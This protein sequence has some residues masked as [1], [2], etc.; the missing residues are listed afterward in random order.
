[1]LFQGT[2]ETGVLRRNRLLPTSVPVAVGIAVLLLLGLFGTVNAQTPQIPMI[3]SGEV[4]VGGELVPDGLQ[5][6]ARIGEYESKPK[7]VKNGKY[8][9][10][11]VGPP[12]VV[13]GGLVTFYLEGVEATQTK[14]WSIGYINLKFNL[15]FPSLP[16]PTPT[17]TPTPTVTPTRTAT[18]VPPTPTST[19][20]ASF[21]AVYSGP[22]V[23]AGGVVPQ[24]AEL[25]AKIDDYVSTPGLIKGEEYRNLVLAPGDARLVG[26][27][28]EFFLGEF[29]AETTDIYESGAFKTEFSLIFL[30]L[31]QPTATVTPMPPTETSVPEPTQTKTPVPSPISTSSPVPPK[32]TP[33]Q[34]PVPP[35]ETS[36]PEPTQTRTPVPSPTPTSS[37][38]PPT[39]TP[40]Q[41]PIPATETA[42][43]APIPTETPMPSGGG[44]LTGTSVSPGTA[45]V[46]GMLMFAPI[47]LLV[48]YRRLRR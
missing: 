31:P 28:I 26:G 39:S 3:F 30:G 17:I 29:R 27:T 34:T 47:A 6:T 13:T 24:G 44:C 20:E 14:T 2:V 43:S 32:S 16:V 37:P 4:R 21:P 25:V 12:T 1:M 15:T 7:T 42:T 18:P 9:G 38:V 33:T 35:T 40:T 10:L 19:A 48:G 46:N 36:V 8:T 45:V 5:V 41:T 23:V 11:T 22:I